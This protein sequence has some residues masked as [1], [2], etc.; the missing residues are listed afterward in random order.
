MATFTTKATLQL[1]ISEWVE[2]KS[3]ALATYGDINTWD[4]SQIT[5]MDH[6]FGSIESFN[7]NIGNW[8]VSRVTTL[9]GLLDD[10]SD[11][12]QD[13]SK[14]NTAK[15]TSMEQ[16]FQNCGD[17]NQDISNWDVS[18]VVT[19]TEM[20]PIPHIG[21]TDNKA[22]AI[23]T[24]WSSNP[25]WGETFSFFDR[26]PYPPSPSMPPPGFIESYGVSVLMP[27]SV[28]V[29][30]LLSALL[31]LCNRAR[32]KRNAIRKAKLL[33]ITFKERA[34]YTSKVKALPT[35]TLG[36]DYK[37]DDASK[38][39]PVFGD[40]NKP[41]SV[42]R[43][44]P[45]GHEFHVDSIDLWLLETDYDPNAPKGWKERARAKKAPMRECP[46]CKA[47]PLTEEMLMQVAEQLKTEV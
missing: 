46:L 41:G 4:V 15:V 18:N 2:D 20:F 40:E 26:C 7:D 36:D 29:V 42:L 1:A 5:D 38:E 3:T 22:C 23:Q 45:C 31:F 19:F 17:F 24:A 30:L 14:W 9:K 44:L 6:L 33:E 43:C 25:K 12:N 8:D 34:A 10:A 27:V 28:I 16:T 35:R 21:I 47:F 11:F 39:C 13:L 37:P 32:L